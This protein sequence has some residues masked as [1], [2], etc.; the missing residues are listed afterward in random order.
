MTDTTPRVYVSSLHAYNSGSLAGFWIDAVDADMT[1]AEW[2][3][4]LSP[5]DRESL[6]DPFPQAHEELWCMDHEN[7]DGWLTGECSP[8]Q[9][10]KIAAAMEAVEQ[11][12]HPVGAVAA[13]ASHIG[14]PVTE[15]DRPTREA[16]ED[17]YRGEWE[18]EED[19]A[20]ELA[21][22]VYHEEW[23]MAEDSHFLTF[24]VDALREAIFV[25]GEGWS[26]PAGSGNV[27]VFDR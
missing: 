7:F 24:D 8:N 23:K 10:A 11:D 19:Y 2:I 15:W 16:F 26:V 25:S 13:W 5:G 3:D 22:D 21:E 1:P 17:S 9:A 12:G 4:K 6:P 27:W 14:E 18:S 20:Q